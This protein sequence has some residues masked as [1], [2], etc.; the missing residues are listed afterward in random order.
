VLA[1]LL[2]RSRN[3]DTAEVGL[4]KKVERK[5]DWGYNPCGYAT[6]SPVALMMGV[7]TRIGKQK[8]G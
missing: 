1:L 6:K 8:L 4:V 5:R 7:V 2:D 3:A